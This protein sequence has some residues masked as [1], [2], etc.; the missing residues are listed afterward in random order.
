MFSHPVAVSGTSQ[1]IGVSKRLMTVKRQQH[2][3]MLTKGLKGRLTL[4]LNSILARFSRRHCWQDSV[5]NHSF[6][7][8]VKFH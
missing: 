5:A 3:E 1:K 4:W 7:D 2:L 8:R 6:A